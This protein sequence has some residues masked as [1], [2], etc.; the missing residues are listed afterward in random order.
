[1]RDIFQQV[2]KSKVGEQGR[3]V[4]D[5]VQALA[6]I[7][8]RAQTPLASNLALLACALCWRYEPPRYAAGTRIP[9]CE[10]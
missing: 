9:T 8:T 7:T 5:H 10:F 6:G 4:G 1:M 3:E 2:E